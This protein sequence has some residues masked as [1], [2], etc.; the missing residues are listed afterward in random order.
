MARR[1][2]YAERH[3]ATVPATGDLDAHIAVVFAAAD[4]APARWAG[5]AGPSDLAALR[6]VAHLVTTRRVPVVSASTRTISELTGRKQ[7]TADRA[8]RRLTRDGWL[9]RVSDGQGTEAATYRLTTPHRPAAD[10]ISTLPPPASV[11]GGSL[12]P[13]PPTTERLRTAIT[14]Q[15]HDVMTTDG[16]GR[17]AAAVHIALSTQPGTIA[18]LATRTGLTRRT[19]RHQ[20][21][22]LA[23]VGLAHFAGAVWAA[24][25]PGQLD[26]AAD[27]LGVAGTVARRAAA[28]TAERAAFRWYLADFAARGRFTVERGQ[29]TPG[30]HTVRG[31]APHPAPS[32]PFPRSGGRAD[33]TGGLRLILTGHGPDPDSVQRVLDTV[34]TRPA[35]PSAPAAVPLRPSPAHATA[36]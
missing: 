13:A 15:S 16:L 10:P 23:E 27:R 19:I 4:A 20:L 5:Q 29:W 21:Q 18:A 28:H 32:M 33:V 14:I 34:P 22:R 25:D 36:A 2:R 31:T 9:V 26:R 7:T 17:Y 24:A 12:A 3:P 35:R 30:R 8:L 1:I 11:A 6:A